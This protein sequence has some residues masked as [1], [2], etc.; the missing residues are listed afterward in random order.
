MP[1]LGRQRKG[2]FYKLFWKILFFSKNTNNPPG[3]IGESTMKTVHIEQKYRAQRMDRVTLLYIRPRPVP[4]FHWL[5]IAACSLGVNE[6]WNYK[7]VIV[8][9]IF[10]LRL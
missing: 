8:R 4:D 3:R 2:D 9:G 5:K 10:A 6:L 7:K 1:T